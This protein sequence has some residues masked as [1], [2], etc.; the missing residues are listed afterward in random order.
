MGLYSG[1][2]LFL[3]RP[4]SLATL[5]GWQENDKLA[6]GIY[7]TYKSQKGESSYFTWF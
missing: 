6:D 3:P 5:Q 4:P 7:H 2:L 1:L